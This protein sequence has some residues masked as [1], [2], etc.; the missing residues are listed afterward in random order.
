MPIPS[1]ASESS[2]FRD[3]S[4]RARVRIKMTIPSTQAPIAGVIDRWYVVQYTDDGVI[5]NPVRG[6]DRLQLLPGEVVT[7]YDYESPPG[8]VRMYQAL[9]V[10]Q[11]LDGELL[12]SDPSPVQMAVVY[13]RNI[14]VKDVFNPT[15][16][17]T[18]PVETKWMSIEKNKPRR[19]VL[20]LGR[21]RPVIV[22][23]AGDYD[24]WSYTYTVVGE[25]N[26]DRLQTVLAADRTYLV[27]TP[28]RQW[29]A[30][31]SGNPTISEDNFSIEEDPARQ[32]TLQF[33][34]VDPV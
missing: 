8:S 22:G 17:F 16:N 2:S 21:E 31:V 26:W 13:L 24:R 4:E 10:Y 23:G 15:I 25:E 6:A 27:Q 3:W 30:Q 12:T 11:L 20:P 29:Y 5:W 34:E 33:T 14:W 19:E 7:I 1:Y 9:T 32:V 18:I 28:H